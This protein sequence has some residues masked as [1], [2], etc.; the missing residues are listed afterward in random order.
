MTIRSAPI[1]DLGPHVSPLIA[2]LWRLKHWGFSAQA[3]LAYLQ[4]CVE[5]GV[6]TMDHAMVYRSEQPFGEAL[7]LKP[8]LREK[9]QIISK[10]GIRP[11]GF[12]EL[13]AHSTNHYDS[14][15][16]AIVA[17]T[18]A[19]LKNLRTDYLDILL[20]HRPDYLMDVYEV[21]EAFAQLKAQ[22]KVRYFGV[23]N[24]SV[25]QFDALQNVWSDGLVSNQVEFS[26]F[27]MQALESGVFEQCTANGVR[28]MLWSC[29]AGG[30]L[31]QPTDAK[32][33]RILKALKKVAA[34]ISADNIEQVVYAWVKAL[35]C[36]PVPLLG[37]SKIER[38]ASAVKSVNLHLTR[39]HWYAIWEAANGSS[40]P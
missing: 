38:V 29:L 19:S 11:T 33:E 24:F 8:E 2:G 35:P 1:S 18:E 28:P 14:S 31:L 5:M 23:S 16:A 17:S 25:A 21:A 20:L 37:T 7:A 6:T 4:Q 22:G 9:M 10:C 32:G 12:G 15:R 30:Q 27:S 36:Q 39:E 13:G 40:V 34:E 26:P 3:L